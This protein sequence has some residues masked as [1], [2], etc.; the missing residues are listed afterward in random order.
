[1]TA[2]VAVPPNADFG[3]VDF[4]EGRDVGD[5]VGEVGDL[6]RGDYFGARGRGEGGGFAEAAL[7]VGEAGE[8][9]GGGEGGGDGEEGHF[10]DAGEAV[11]EDKDGERVGGERGGEGEDAGEG[12]AVGGCEG[13]VAAGHDC[14]IGMIR[15]VKVVVDLVVAIVV[16]SRSLY[17]KMGI[18]FSIVLTVIF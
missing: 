18:E 1:M 5:C 14:G 6:N 16:A 13:E 4:R 9:E 7:V 8:G 17:E 15:V 11:G 3:L 12:D 10:F 2:R